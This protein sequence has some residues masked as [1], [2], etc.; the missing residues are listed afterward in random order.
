MTFRLKTV[1]GATALV[2]LS[3][4]AAQAETVLKWAHVYETSEPFHTE[5]VWAAEEIAKRT[6][7]GALQGRGLSG[8]AARQGSRHQPGPEA[9]H[10]RHHHFRFELRGARLQADRRH[11]FPISSGIRAT[12]WPTRKA[13]SSSACPRAMRMPPATTSPPSPT[14]A[15]ATRRPTSRSR[16]APTWR[17]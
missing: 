14:M 11:L 10:R 6:E 17:A 8:L 13:T 16:N 5:S 3:A 2:L 7:G 9:R 12:F 15:R 1:L 4:L